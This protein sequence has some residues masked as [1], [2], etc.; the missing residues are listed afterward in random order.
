M[1][2]LK[3]EVEEMLFISRLKL[4][5]IITLFILVGAVHQPA[6]SFAQEKETT[7]S[8]Y[9]G[10][11]KTI[12]VTKFDAHGAFV[13]KYGSWD[14]GGGLSAML[15]TELV[16]TKRFIVVDRADLD[17]VL[18][19]QQMA[20]DQ[21]ATASVPKVGQL[22]GA[23]LLV[24]GSV[25][26]FDEEESGGGFSIGGGTSKLLGSI[27]PQWRNGHVTI[28]LRLIDTTTGRILQSHTADAN[29]KAIG[30]A[31][32]V[33]HKNISLGGDGFDK[34]PLGKATRAA[35]NDSVGFVVHEMDDVPWQALVAKVKGNKIYINAGQNASVRLGDVLGI[36]RV[37]DTVTDPVSK[38][39]LGVE[40]QQIGQVQ[41]IKVAPRYSTA[42]F[43]GKHR[44]KVGDILR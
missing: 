31:L 39:V 33:A 3:K 28:D 44:P 15:V 13:A 10:P 26:E 34:T 25:T 22:L 5:S 42:Q 43:G 32:E 18:R 37:V 17:A 9:H 41:I 23:Q 21:L 20:V 12:A 19:E 6:R 35:I 40:E 27:A 29:I 7:Y 14:I 16:K 11:K 8:P 4:G 24:R 2:K 38:E 1:L 30:V 36:Y